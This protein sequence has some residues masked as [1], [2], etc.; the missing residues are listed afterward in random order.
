MNTEKYILIENI[1]NNILK[2]S[3]KIE[4]LSEFVKPLLKS[5]KSFLIKESSTGA[6][7]KEYAILLG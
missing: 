2:S 6:I 4:E 1:T 7:I 3:D 5:G